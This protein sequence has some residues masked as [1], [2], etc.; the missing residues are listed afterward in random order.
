M[1]TLDWIIV[2]GAILMAVRGYQRGFV[3]GALSLAGFVGGAVLGA[4]LAPLLLPDGS[5]SPW[6]PVMALVAAVVVGSLTSGLLERLGHSIRGSLRL[7]GV[8]VLDGGLGAVLGA[9][10]FLAFA[11]ILGAVALQ[12]PGIRSLRAEVQRSAVL[13]ELNDTLPPSGPILQA[14]ARFDPLPLITGPAPDSIAAPSR[15]TLAQPGARSARTGT[16]R[17][18]GVAC[19]LGV[20]GSGW[21]AR[22][23]LVVTNAHVVAGTGDH[24]TVQRRGRGYRYDARAVAFDVRNDIAVLSVPGLGGEPLSL[25]D[26][27][28]EADTSGAI[29]GYPENGPFTAV[30][31][32]VGATVQVR[33][34]DAYGRGPVERQMTPLRGRVRHG[35]SGGPVVDGKGRV[36]ATVFAASTDSGPAGGYGVPNSVVRSLLDMARRDGRTVSTEPCSR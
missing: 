22:N 15:R 12:T 26:G 17:V 13:S 19:G 20:E 29:L 2:V 30:P 34:E 18:L 25:A 1:T 27:N 23:G 35:N 21:I 5:Q 24:L 10:V 31:A 9:V 36:L 4:R 8:G 28:P 14:L 32:R 6:A 11:W 3:I 33:S 7:P 16:V